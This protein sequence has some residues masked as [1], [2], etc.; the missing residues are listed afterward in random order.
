M[1]SSYPSH[2]TSFLHRYFWSRPDEDLPRALRIV[3]CQSSMHQGDLC[4][5]TDSD[6]QHI[7]T[8]LAGNPHTPAAVLDH[9]A[10]CVENLS[11]LQRVADNPATGIET[12][13]RLACHECPQVRVAVAEN[14]N[15]DIEILAMLVK[16]SEVDVRF[17]LA[18]SHQLPQSILEQL[19]RDDNPYVAHR[20]LRTRTR[21][22]GQPPSG[23]S[24]D[25]EPMPWS[26]R[27]RTRRAMRSS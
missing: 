5:A 10:F 25:V 19:C 4:P 12:L 16:D 24:A 18:E 14:G 22:S 7:N 13:K 2:D 23:R 17:T 11:I 8:V 27:K 15:V 26:G 3:N 9:L 1:F 6:C 21:L 20:A